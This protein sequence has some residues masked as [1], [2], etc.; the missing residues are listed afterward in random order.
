MAHGTVKAA[1]VRD[2]ASLTQLGKAQLVAIVLEQGQALAERDRQIDALRAELAQARQQQSEQTQRTIN[3]TANQPSSKKP[4]WDKDGNLLRRRRGKRR[5]GKR[6]GC[7][8]RPKLREPDV[9]HVIALDDCPECG[10]DLRRRPGAARPGR[11]VEDIA[12]PPAQTTLS[13]EI[14]HTKWC[15]GCRKMVS[16]K[17]ER[18]LPGSDIGL[19]ATIEIAWLWVMSALSLPKIQALCQ[20]FRALS[21]STAGISR[22]MIRLAGILQP[23]YEEILAD[24]RDGARIWADETGWRVKGKLWWLW[25]FAN[26]R[27]AFYWAEACRGSPVVERILGPLFLGVLIVDAWSAYNALSCAKQTCM[28]HIFRKIRAFIDAWP[29]YSSLLRFYVKLRRLI[30]DGEKLQR[31]R[32]EID[33][34]VFQRRLKALHSRCDALLAWRNPNPVLAKVIGQVRRQ[35]RHLLT[36]VEHDGVPSH[37]NYGEY[38]IKKGVLKRKVSGGS[39]SAEGA[40]AYACIQSVAMTCQ[41][42]QLSFHAFLRASLIHYIRTGTPMGLADYEAG[43][44]THKEAA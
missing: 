24:V 19:N 15:A 34:A 16:S 35:R 13:R 40:R 2:R 11:I 41:L 39:M 10:R 25:I 27:S 31:A 36:F 21:L 43:L 9:T 17:S 3:L 4:E 30:Q 8:N 42:R 14:E 44:Q 22:M 20:S 1:P 32:T 26:E 38:I 18:A 29:H 6:R 33:E 5:R 12:P 37:N 23:V 7:G 28:A